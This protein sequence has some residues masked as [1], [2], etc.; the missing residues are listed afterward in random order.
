[1]PL[2]GRIAYW[3]AVSSAVSE[4]LFAKRR[5]VEGKVATMSGEIIT[6]ICS[7]EP[8]GFVISTSSGRLAHLAL[9]DAAG[10][11]GIF[12]TMMRGSTGLGGLLGALRA[13]SNRRDIVAVRAGRVIRIGERE[14]FVATARGNFSRWGINRTGGYT[15]TTD[16]DLREQILYSL[17]EEELLRGRNKDHFA[18]V[19]L[20]V[21]GYSQSDYS[22]QEYNA[23]LLVLCA[24]TTPGST[25]VY[26]VVALKLHTNGKA[27]VVDFH[28]IKSYMEGWNQESA[29]A[30]PRIYLPAP[31]KTAFI[32]FPKA[33][34]IMSK[35][36]GN[37]AEDI[38]DGWYE[39]VVDFRGDLSI[40]IVGSGQEFVEKDTAP[41]GS[42]T[43]DQGHV[44]KIKN[45]GVILLAKGAGILRVEAFDVG[46]SAK[47]VTAPVTAKSKLEQAIYYGT[48]SEVSPFLNNNRNFSSTINLS[49]RILLTSLADRRSSSP[50]TKWKMLP[51]KSAKKF[52]TATPNISPNSFPPSVATWISEHYTSVH[53]SNTYELALL[54]TPPRKFSGNSSRMLRSLKPPRLS[55]PPTTSCCK[56]ILMPVRELSDRSSTSSLCLRKRPTTLCVS[57]S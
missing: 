8:A 53:W 57:G 5:G 10:R 33:V 4:G 26:I 16:V 25:T 45:P 48:R 19:D 28:V 7:A 37:E 41:A 50:F 6:S 40:E 20:Q 3:D 32:V 34:V 12:I 38:K 49:N 11:P 23:H 52:S 18:V 21:T 31:Q 17:S 42:F 14:V 29:Q 36:N 39:D 46:S 35:I 22:E 24:I 1:M 54:D 55:G 13:G 51:S 15:N 56:S 30:A 27:D 43:G 9:R 47:P 44:K 2:T